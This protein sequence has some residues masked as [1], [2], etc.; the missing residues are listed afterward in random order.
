MINRRKK[1][2]L[3]NESGSVLLSAK[4]NPQIVNA[5]TE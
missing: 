4:K 2:I 1:F 5:I 3:L